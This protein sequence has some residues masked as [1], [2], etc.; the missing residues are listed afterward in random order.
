MEPGWVDII[1]MALAQSRTLPPP[2]PMTLSQPRLRQNSVPLATTEEGGS[3]GTSLKISQGIPAFSRTSRSSRHRPS[4]KMEPPVTRR[5]WRQPA[6]SSSLG[7]SPAAWRP[8]FRLTPPKQM[9]LVD[10]KQDSFQ[11][12]P[13]FSRMK[14]RTWPSGGIPAEAPI[15]ETQKAP[16]ALP[17]MTER[18]RSHSLARP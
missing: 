9:V 4:F 18:S 11:N 6:F 14:R 1:L 8:M 15:W 2:R 12:V 10:M 7:I 13:F 3:L 16:T 5:G 17:K